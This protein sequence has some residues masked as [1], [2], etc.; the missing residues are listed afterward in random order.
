MN[1]AFVGLRAFGVLGALV[2]LVAFDL[3]ISVSACT[4]P[5]GHTSRTASTATRLPN[6]NMTSAGTTAGVV[7]EVSSF[8]TKLPARASTFVPMPLRLLTFPLKSRCNDWFL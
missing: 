8:W 4:T 6:P 3:A 1:D 2:G 7:D 5:E